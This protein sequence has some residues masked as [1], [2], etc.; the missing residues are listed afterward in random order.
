[1]AVV[2]TSTLARHQPLLA[3]QS[4]AKKSVLSPH[5]GYVN[6]LSK[7]LPSRSWHP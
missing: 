5:A 6:F 3:L 1:M 7:I 2:T 4:L